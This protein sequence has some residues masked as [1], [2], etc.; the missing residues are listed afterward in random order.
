MA[1]DT[2]NTDPQ[3]EVAPFIPQNNGVSPSSRLV[4]NFNPNGNA[5]PIN[6]PKGKRIPAATEMRKAVVEELKAATARGVINPN[7]SKTINK[8]SRRTLASLSDLAIL[9]VV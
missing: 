9:R 1:I 8:I 6:N 2:A 5:I 4:A 3:I 7:S